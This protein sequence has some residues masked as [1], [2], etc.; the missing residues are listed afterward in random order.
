MLGVNSPR[1]FCGM[2]ELVFKT[3]NYQFK[4]FNIKCLIS[5][6][7]CL[8]SVSKTPGMWMYTNISC[9]ASPHPLLNAKIRCT[10]KEALFPSAMLEADPV[11]I[12]LK[13]NS[14]LMKWEYSTPWQFLGSFFPKASWR[15]A[16][17]WDWHDC[18]TVLW[19]WEMM[20]NLEAASGRLKVPCNCHILEYNL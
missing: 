18:G 16:W 12:A 8:G 9:V 5:L 19:A 2:W 14:H 4:Y 17:V 6:W 11:L 3:V 13:T 15:F 7:N 1:Q 10:W 20:Q